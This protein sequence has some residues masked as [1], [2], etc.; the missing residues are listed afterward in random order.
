MTRTLW[1]AMSAAGS[2]IATSPTRIMPRRWWPN[3]AM[4]RMPTRSR[5]SLPSPRRRPEYHEG[6]MER[7]GN[8]LSHVRKILALAD[9]HG[10]EAVNRAMDDA[11]AF[12]AFSSEY[13]AHLIQARGRQLPQPSALVLMRRQDVLELDLPPA[14]LSPYAIPGEKDDGHDRC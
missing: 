10:A 12:A 4:P 13:I 2:A 14:D 6:L 5:A 1:P 11:L 7:R 3:A 9:I 8:A